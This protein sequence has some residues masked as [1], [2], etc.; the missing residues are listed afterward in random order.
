MNKL[1]WTRVEAALD[2][3]TDPFDD[4]R[5]AADLATDPET[6]R[7]A[8]QLMT[9]LEGLAPAAADAQALR[10]RSNRNERVASVA[11]A[12]LLTAIGWGFFASIGS[13]LVA[14]TNRSNH[15]DVG[16]L[17]DQVRRARRPA[18]SLSLIIEHISPP[19]ARGARV[20]LEARRVVSW[21]LEGNTP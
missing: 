21:S 4:M 9:R 14:D 7:A 20:T 17:H 18:N 3:R 19:P 12:V 10:S 8:R 5:L 11:A 13:S 2:A 1:L 16:A 6:E 15:D